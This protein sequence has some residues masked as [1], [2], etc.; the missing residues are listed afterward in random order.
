VSLG[1]RIAEV[2]NERLELTQRQLADQLGV[3]PVSI[4]RWERD[5]VEPKTRYVRE[6]AELSGVPVGWFYSGDGVAA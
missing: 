2:R 1:E 6:I 4:S 5:K 3:D